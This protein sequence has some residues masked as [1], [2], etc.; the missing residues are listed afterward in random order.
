MKFWLT[1]CHC[2]ISSN[3]SRIFSIHNHGM[4]KYKVLIFLEKKMDVFTVD[5]YM[6]NISYLFIYKTNVE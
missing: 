5:V 1:E 3:Y 4:K 2:Y 6:K